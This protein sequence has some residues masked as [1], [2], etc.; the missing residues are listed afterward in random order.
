MSGDRTVPRSPARVLIVDDSATALHLLRAVFEGENYEVVT[1]ADADDG[2]EK[3]C[4]CQPDLIV[5]DSVMPGTDGF[6]FVRRLRD[7]PQTGFIPMIMLTA[8]DPQPLDAASTDPQPDA[9]IR[10]SG[11]MGPLLAHVRVA[12]E[13][14]HRGK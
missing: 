11:D 13:R 1:A 8:A 7:S 6:A 3:A 14:R 2:F 9:L 5:T 4:Q 10:K 12:L